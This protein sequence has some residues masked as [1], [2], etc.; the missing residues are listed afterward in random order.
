MS[1]DSA[2]LGGG[3]SATQCTTHGTFPGGTPGPPGALARS[4]Q[5]VG[6]QSAAPREGGN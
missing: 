4:P 3:L 6:P 2:L 5:S 1:P